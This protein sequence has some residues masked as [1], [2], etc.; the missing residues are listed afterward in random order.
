MRWN[1][2]FIDSKQAQEP[3]I[4]LEEETRQGVA[5]P[6]VSI[7][8]VDAGLTEEQR[9][10]IRDQT[11]QFVEFAG[12]EIESAIQEGDFISAFTVVDN[13]LT[14]LQDPDV[15]KAF[16]DIGF[17]LGGDV[18]GGIAVGAAAAKAILNKLADEI[19][20]TD[21]KTAERQRKLRIAALTMG[22]IQASAEVILKSIGDPIR[23]ALAG[24]QTAI[25]AT[26]TAKA[27]QQLK[28]EPLSFAGGGFTGAG[29]MSDTKEPGRKIAGVVHDNEY[30]VP[31]NVITSRMG[32]SLVGQLEKMR[33]TGSYAQGGFAG[34][35]SLAR[36]AEREISVG[37]DIADT[38][39]RLPSPVV[40]VKEINTVQNRVQ[41]KE[42]TGL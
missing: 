16:E 35:S 14:Q 37:I 15:K 31:T 21:R 39:S 11:F 41:V 10:G 38:I 34:V 26:T 32:S 29:F 7:V 6:G 19:E 4:S 12:K 2:Q 27:I 1:Q 33:V 13:L 30:V 18:V 22:A 40:S 36:Q 42:D 24:V 25:I 5:L 28:A 20:V 8:N 17:E 3:S 9:Q 23:L